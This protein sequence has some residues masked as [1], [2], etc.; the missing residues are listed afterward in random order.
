MFLNNRWIRTIRF[1][2]RLMAL[3]MLLVLTA[4]SGGGGGGTSSSAAPTAGYIVAMRRNPGQEAV[5]TYRADDGSLVDQIPGAQLEGTFDTKADARVVVVWGVRGTTYYTKLGLFTS[6]MPVMLGTEAG[7]EYLALGYIE[8]PTAPRVLFRDQT[9]AT[10]IALR[11]AN[12][13]GTDS[14]LLISGCEALA[15]DLVKTA[16]SGVLFQC[17]KGGP[18]NYKIWYSDGVAPAIELPGVATRQPLRLT[19]TRAILSEPGPPTTVRT[20][21]LDG[22]GV[23]SGDAFIPGTGIEQF[24]DVNADGIALV[25]TLSAGTWTV[26]TGPVETFASTSRFTSVG[27]PEYEEMSADGAKFA[28]IYRNQAGNGIDKAWVQPMAGGT[29]S[30]AEMNTLSETMNDIRFVGNGKVVVTR[31]TVASPTGTYVHNILNGAELPGSQIGLNQKVLSTKGDYALLA[32]GGQFVS[33]SLVDYTKSILSANATAPSPTLRDDGYVTFTDD[34]HNAW[35]AT[36]DGTLKVAIDSVPSSYVQNVG[37]GE[38][39]RV[40]LVMTRFPSLDN[41]IVMFDLDTPTVPAVTVIGGPTD[42]SGFFFPN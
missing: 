16:T 39:N 35:I 23:D 40:F 21:V 24:L 15:N 4:C 7:H 38:G 20:Q 19:A 3:A 34:N 27:V 41:D 36:A 30:P 6:S 18:T 28:M 8:S 1:I 5:S 32:G 13:D 2:P 12:L 37:D 9:S 33:A 25:R 14:R 17:A 31:G 42:D 29:V 11:T 26:Y 10:N 22:V